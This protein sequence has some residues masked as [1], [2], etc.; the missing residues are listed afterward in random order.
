MP[1]E[2]KIFPATPRRRRRAKRRGQVVK[3]QEVNSVLVLVGGI[4]LLR[5][6]GYPLFERLLSLSRDIWAKL[7]CFTS[8]SQD[9]YLKMQQAFLQT[10]FLLLPFFLFIALIAVTSNIMQVGF[11]FSFHPL[12]P[13]L[14]RINPVSGLKRIFS[15]EGLVRLL[16]SLLKIIFI[17]CIAYLTIKG[18]L[19]TIFSLT[20][21]EVDKVLITSLR[22]GFKLLI[23]L[24]IGII[25]LALMDYVFQKRRYERQL[26][27][28][29][30]EFKEELK[31][32][33]GNPLVKSRIRSLQ[34][35]ILRSRMMQK[36]PQAD[37]VITNPQRLAVALQYERE[38]MNAPV[39]IAK[40][41]GIIAE[42][43]KEIARKHG[44]PIVENRWLA[45]MLY[46]SVEI[47]EEIPVK[48]YQAVAEI[49][50]YIY[51][52]RRKEV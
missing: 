40:G 23:S 2:E 21:Q 25:P 45:Q 38:K 28:T 37:V 10:A 33:E 9:I 17:G 26:R 11:V 49:L 20:G 4:M 52:L 51:R 48:F 31:E 3:S 29:R 27:M 35:Q 15:R 5:F 24:S 13:D 47:G 7:Y 12:I 32:T 44:V 6:L 34:R 41:A 36:V 50:A 39:V 43:I 14:D 42:K 8:S 19:P 46:K 1:E 16:I 22:L 30:E 18:E